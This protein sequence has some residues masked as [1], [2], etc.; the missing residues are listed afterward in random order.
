MP[1]FSTFPNRFYLLATFSYYFRLSDTLPL[2]LKFS[3][4]AGFLAL[5]FLTPLQLRVELSEDVKHSQLLVIWGQV[6]QFSVNHGKN[7]TKNSQS[8]HTIGIEQ[9]S[10]DATWINFDIRMS[11]FHQSHSVY[12]LVYWE[13][14]VYENSVF[15]FGCL[16]QTLLL[17]FPVLKGTLAM[18][19]LQ[20]LLHWRRFSSQNGRTTHL[21][22]S[23]YVADSVE[24][25]ISL[26]CQCSHI[27]DW[28]L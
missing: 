1:V 17:K 12:R 23:L 11:S 27:Q 4:M 24:S 18:L 7:K 19:Q 3:S 20:P 22:S 21:L 16:S 26:E 8:H 2:C 15:Y 6:G 13:M 10:I 9:K 5:I 28:N 14:S 25:I